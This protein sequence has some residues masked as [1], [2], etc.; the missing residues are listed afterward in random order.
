MDTVHSAVLR[1]RPACCTAGMLLDR[2]VRSSVLQSRY[3]CRTGI[4]AILG[5]RGK[6]GECRTLIPSNSTPATETVM[7]ALIANPLSRMTSITSTKDELRS[8]TGCILIVTVAFGITVSGSAIAVWHVHVVTCAPCRKRS[9]IRGALAANDCSAASPEPDGMPG[10]VAPPSS[11]K[12]MA[13]SMP[14]RAWAI[15]LG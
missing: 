4:P 8:L 9:A 1:S 7:S 11:S 10:K 2:L 12:R 15:S 3:W 5:G 6:G 14:M 13:L